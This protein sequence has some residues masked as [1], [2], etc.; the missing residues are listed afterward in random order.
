MSYLYTYPRP[1]DSLTNGRDLPLG[2]VPPALGSEEKEGEGLDQVQRDAQ[3]V[4]LV[5]GPVA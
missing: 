5:Q 1:K 4:R 2:R 3:L